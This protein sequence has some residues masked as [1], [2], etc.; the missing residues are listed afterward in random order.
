MKVKICESISTPEEGETGEITL[1]LPVE[2]ARQVVITAINEG[3]ES[4]SYCNIEDPDIG[5]VSIMDDEIDEI[6]EFNIR[7]KPER[8]K[9][10]LN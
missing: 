6:L 10:E 7:I 3:L 1:W 9:L 8:E 5:V 2:F 4:I